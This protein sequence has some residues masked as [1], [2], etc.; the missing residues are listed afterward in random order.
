MANTSIYAAF[1][2]FWQH[3]VAVLGE[4][5]DAEHTHTV[6]DVSGLTNVVITKTLTSDLYGDE[7]P[8]AGT[9]GRIFFKKV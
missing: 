1:E 3:I 9:E 4:K 2:R 5:A 8:D 7:L 6:S